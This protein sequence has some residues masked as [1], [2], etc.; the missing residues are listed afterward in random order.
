MIADSLSLP[1]PAM[2]PPD[3]GP[4]PVSLFH[5]GQNCCAT[6]RAERVAFLV[7]G[8]AYFDAFVRAAERAERS[9]LILAW[10]FDSRTV[11][12]YDGQ[13]RPLET[14]GEFLNRL[15]TQRPRLR[16]S[17]LDW[18]FPM[19][20]GTDREYSPIFG[21]AWKPHRHIKFRFDDTHPLAGSHHQKVVVIDDKVAFAGGLDITNKRWDTP[22]H[23]PGDPRRVFEEEPYPPFHDV[24]IAVDGEAARELAE[25]ARSRW[26]AG[27]GRKVKPVTTSGDPWPEE[28]EPE[29][30]NVPVGI[31]CTSPEVGDNPGVRHVET[32]YLD[33]IAQA[34]RYIYIENQYFTSERIGLAL[35]ARLK[36]PDPPEIAVVTRLLSHGWLEENTMHVLR[37]RLVRMLRDA[38]AKGRFH[39]WF[40]HLDGLCEGT[41]IDL[42][43][44][45]MV[46]DD[47][48]LRIGSSNISN[49]SMGVDTECDVT[50]E[51]QGEPGRRKAIR[52]FRDRLLAEHAGVEVEVLAPAV[53]RLGS[54]SAAVKELSRGPRRLEHLE[55]PEVSEALL[56]AA[57]IG[58]MEAP[59][60]ID[61]L[62][63]DFAHDEETFV[64]P[65]RR[66]LVVAGFMLALI[67]ALALLWRYTPLA[68][69]VTADN[70]IG[71]ARV[72]AE[73]WWAPLMVVLAYTP[74]SMVM[75]PRP[76]LTMAAVVVFGPWEGFAY[77]MTGVVL[78]GTAGYA[79]GR[80]VHRDTVRRLAGPRLHRLTGVL[81]RRGI[82]AVTLVRLVPIAPYLVVNVVMGAMRIRLHHFVLGTFLGMLPGGLAATV[83][84][85]QVAVALMNPAR[86]NLWVVAGA[87]LAFAALALAGHQLLAYL[88]RR[89][90]RR[91]RP[92]ARKPS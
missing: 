73:H 12:R 47:E 2:A 89:E 65:A 91:R 37:T 71:I 11:L 35:E 66:P 85:D 60:S 51:A 70:V 75:F 42:H 27:T 8:D 24:M 5:R 32:L 54:M 87:V 81:Q 40:P 80:M 56:A 61:G 14:M 31:A 23:A 28:L 79:V 82:V 58:D 64:E 46:V 67:A 1:D 44:K 59:I 83:L 16:I 78:A 72:F 26:Q 86:V 48:W 41:C 7:D 10:D 74:A 62:V 88:D 63:Q 36:E 45:V 77:A 52:A 13:N 57:K 17:I 22:A 21:L 3:S 38:D 69:A 19:V 4:A 9:I 6:A 18:D 43:S 49:R 34:K 92:R 39:A 50:V 68:A 30:L 84:S 15:C 55:A 20:Y 53:E 29:M 33:M 76:L 25:L 90:Q